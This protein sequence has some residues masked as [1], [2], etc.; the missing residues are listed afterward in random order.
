MKEGFMFNDD[1][2]DDHVSDGTQ[3]NSQN[4]EKTDV[5]SDAVTPVEASESHEASAGTPVGPSKD[6]ALGKIIPFNAEAEAALTA[7][8]AKDA[9][10]DAIRNIKTAVGDLKK[11]LAPLSESL[12]EAAGAIRDGVR[13]SRKDADEEKNKKTPSVAPESPSDA[14]REAGD[15]IV[16]GIQKLKERVA[17]TKIDVQSVLATEF[18]HFADANLKEGEYTLDE[19]GKRVVKVD[20][21]FLQNHGNA[22]IPALLRGT[23]GSFFRAVLGSD[24]VPDTE[25]PKDTAKTTDEPDEA[26]KAESFADEKKYRVQFDFAS[27]ISNMIQNAQ[28][29][30]T[31]D[32]PVSQDDIARSKQVFA[33]SAKIYEEALNGEDV[34]NAKERL[35][36]AAQLHPTPDSDADQ[37]DKLSEDDKA[38]AQIQAVDEK[39]QRILDIS[40]EFEQIAQKDD[41]KP[42]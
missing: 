16:E 32:S 29:V 34:S 8:A 3:K 7:E 19:D 11:Q 33:E 27:A 22:L 23:V 25:A 37:D 39:H 38:P 26:E 10:E 42:E 4:D 14:V 30:A 20:P 40:R 6:P 2:K 18:E 21:A 41:S 31:T 36:E 24:L 15:V 13:E 12:H 9:I 5:S 1:I 28:F 35:E 17:N